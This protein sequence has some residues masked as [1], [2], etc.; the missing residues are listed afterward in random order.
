MPK[1]VEIPLG[2]QHPALKEPESFTLYLEGERVAASNV[3][4]GYNHRGM[5]KACEQRSYIQDLYLIERTCGIC[6]HSHT[7]AFI[8]ATE[9]VAGLEIPKRAKYIRVLVGELERVHS[10]LLWVGVAAHEIG[11][12]SL[13]MYSWRDREIVMDILAMLTGGRVQ[14]SI[15][16]LGGVRRDVSESQKEQIL[17]AVDILEE[18][19]KYYIEVATTETTMMGRLKNVGG[20]TYDIAMRFHASGPLARAS[21]VTRDVRRD[22]PYL[23][24]DEL[25]FNVI[26]NDGC[27]VFARVVVRALELME[28]YKLI[29]QAV[30]NMPD[31]D[32]TVKAPRK[33]PANE[34]T[35]R[36][37][38][39]RGEDIHYVRGNGTE[40][41]ERVKL[42]APT[43]ANL[44]S[45]SYMIDGGYLADVPIVIAAIDPCFSC[46]DRAISI[47]QIE[48]G[49]EDKMDWENLRKY[50]I[51]WYKKRGFDGHKIKLM[52]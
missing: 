50:S 28:S 42:R 14:Y 11:F 8:T 21:G 3:T 7:T 13:F 48:N 17:K 32:L 6:S 26:T 12:D 37:E 16:T 30:K 25:D 46:T 2:P 40:K 23:V 38:A 24:Y 51:D 52:H 20:L 1:R 18:R 31:G 27:D 15:N 22:D 36:Y 10:H 49:R 33:L 45:I 44:A 4:I 47:K 29:R 5:E 19:T 9:E 39:P 35:V 41:P 43:M 34:A